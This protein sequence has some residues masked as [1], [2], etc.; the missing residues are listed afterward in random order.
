MSARLLRA[1]AQR[2]L[3]EGDIDGATIRAVAEVDMALQVSEG[4]FLI[5]SLVGIAVG[6]HSELIT[7]QILDSGKSTQANRD[8]LMAA[9]NRIEMENVFGI[10]DAIELEGKIAVQWL[11]SEFTGDDARDVSGLLPYVTGAKPTE[12]DHPLD[13]FTD[14]D[15]VNDLAKLSSAYDALLSAWNAEDA[16]EQLGD[17]YLAVEAGEFGELAKVLLPALSNVRRSTDRISVTITATKKR[18]AETE[19]QEDSESDEP[20]IG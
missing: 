13:S 3:A 15:I 5:G 9:Y 8:L 10:I 7:D 16:T 12:E 20:E 1:D 19:D 6:Q 18:I 11:E 4:N 17:I 2:L 14:E